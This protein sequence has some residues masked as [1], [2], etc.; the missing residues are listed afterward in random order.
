[1][2]EVSVRSVVYRDADG[3]RRGTER[4]YPLRRGG[5]S[6][7]TT[8]TSYPAGSGAAGGGGVRFGE[9]VIYES[10]FKFKNTDDTRARARRA[11]T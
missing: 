10:K 3:T 11:H 6:Y 4:T 2:C 5:E 9:S 7:Y 1:M 8:W